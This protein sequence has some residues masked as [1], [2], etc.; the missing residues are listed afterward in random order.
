MRS[1][2]IAIAPLILAAPLLGAEG[3]LLRLP[4]DD[5]PPAV[6]ALGDLAGT[7]AFAISRDGGR[8]ASAVPDDEK[9]QRSLVRF[10][11]PGEAAPREV[12]VNGEVRDL[13]FSP[14]AE[15]LFAIAVRRPK[16]SI[17][18]AF[19]VRI[20]TGT[21]KVSREIVLPLQVQDADLLGSVRATTD[22]T[23]SVAGTAGYDTYGA[24]RSTTG[25]MGAY[26][27]TGEYTDP[28]GLIH[29]RARQYDPSLGR[30]PSVDT[31]QPNPGSGD[32]SRGATRDDADDRH[33]G[34]RG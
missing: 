27:Y 29:L 3:G 8:A 17:P 23:G 11:G 22:S 33:R 1:L 31:V 26:G 28:T 32:G 19:L 15:E 6:R 14:G 10:C 13:V 2:T 16:R 25:T 30:F 24:T 18:Q 4:A 7:S 5:A 34:L 9:K 21:A 12:R 20:D